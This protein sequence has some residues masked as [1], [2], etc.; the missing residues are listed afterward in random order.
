MSFK[1]MQ[2][3]VVDR[4]HIGVTISGTQYVMTHAEVDSLITAICMVRESFAVRPS[5]PCQVVGTCSLCRY[6]SEDDSGDGRGCCAILLNDE[7]ARGWRTL[8]TDTCVHYDVG[9]VG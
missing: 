8:P 2:V 3:R 9:R 5:S 1:N 6:W 4:D 7:K